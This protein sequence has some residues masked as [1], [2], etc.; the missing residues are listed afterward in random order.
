M[1]FSE[2][3]VGDAAPD[4]SGELG[5]NL[6]LTS[7]KNVM[8]DTSTAAVEEAKNDTEVSPSAKEHE[9][10]TTEAPTSAA[11]PSPSEKIRAASTP[12]ATAA[13]AAVE[14]A[15]NDTEV[16]PSA[17]EHERATTG[18]PTSA[19][20]PPPSEKNRAASTP[21]TTAASAPL[22]NLDSNSSSSDP[23]SDVGEVGNNLKI[24]YRNDL[25]TD[26]EKAEAERLKEYP[27]GID[28]NDWMKILLCFLCFYSLLALLFYVANA[29]NYAAETNEVGSSR[30]CG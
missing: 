14:E 26:A 11:K 29:A 1:S 30:A 17:K 16:S 21:K 7:T 4:A 9:R 12:K 28:Y 22:S 5:K 23:E 8:V 19:A 27:L 25:R 10:A 18:A 2:G 15:K 6:E 3:D 24:H 20:K 13:T